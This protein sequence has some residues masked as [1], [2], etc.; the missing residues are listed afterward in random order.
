[1]CYLHFKN[2]PL[3]PISFHLNL[4]SSACRVHVERKLT[5][6]AV[7]WARLHCSPLEL[8]LHTLL[9]EISVNLSPLPWFLSDGSGLPQRRGASRAPPVSVAGVWWPRI[10][11]H[12][13]YDNFFSHVCQERECGVDDKVYEP[14]GS[15]RG[16]VTFHLTGGKW[17]SQNSRRFAE[18]R[19]VC[20]PIW[21]S[22]TGVLFRSHRGEKGRPSSA[23]LSP[24]QRQTRREEIF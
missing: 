15:G 6:S 4:L 7:M 18:R 19:K 12:Q 22:A 24:S 1:M 14:C 16:A 3:E 8:S 2:L 23:S 9:K 17:K 20:P 5:S 10:F 11:L 13:R 21:D